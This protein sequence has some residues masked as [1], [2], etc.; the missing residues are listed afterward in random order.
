MNKQ[1]G[2]AYENSFLSSL[3]CFAHG[4]VKSTAYA[5]NEVP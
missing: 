3:L 2:E 5:K 1:E 4:E